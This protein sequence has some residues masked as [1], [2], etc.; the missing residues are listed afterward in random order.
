MREANLRVEGLIRRMADFLRKLL[1]DYT[2]NIDLNPKYMNLLH[3]QTEIPLMVT[4]KRESSDDAETI[5][6]RGGQNTT[7]PYRQFGIRKDGD[8][9]MIGNSSQSGRV[10]CY[11][12]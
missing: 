6:L 7:V 5:D 11:H 2:G 1:P 9:L 12:N 10:R 8:T 4:P 3:R